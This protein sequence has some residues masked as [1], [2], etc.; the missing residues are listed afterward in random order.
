MLMLAREG[1]QGGGDNA[2]HV[3]RVAVT[4][5]F[6]RK[7]VYSKNRDFLDFCLYPPNDAGSG[8]WVLFIG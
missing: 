5:L 7:V 8:R 6:C 4:A 2:L 3:V 1:M